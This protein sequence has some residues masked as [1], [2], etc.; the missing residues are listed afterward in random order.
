[1]N[2]IAIQHKA[3]PAPANHHAGQTSSAGTDKGHEPKK[4]K[5]VHADKNQA[6]KSR[7]VNADKE[8]ANASK[9]NAKKS[10]DA[11]GFDTMVNQ[12]IG[13]ST[14]NGQQDP[15]QQAEGTTEAGI[16]LLRSQVLGSGADI[17]KL[18]QEL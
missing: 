11:S 12:M 17:S 16:P 3:S 9:N 5:S 18:L 4:I 10:D 13:S 1:M 14:Q 2:A 7:S 8:P 6:P 15:T